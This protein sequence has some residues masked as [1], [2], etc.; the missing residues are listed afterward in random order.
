MLDRRRFALSCAALPATLIS[1]FAACGK[2]QKEQM[3]EITFDLGKNIA[4]TA[5]ASGVPQYSTQDVNGLL[6]YSVSGIPAEIPA[7]FTRPGFEIVWHPLFGFELWADKAIDPNLL[8]EQASLQLANSIRSHSAAQAFV[9]QT[10]AQFAK[11]KW[12][13]YVDP[14]WNTLL[15]GRS[16]LLDES[17][18]IGRTLDAIDPAYKIP[19]AD[20][21]AVMSGHPA[22]NWV[23]DNVH[24]ELSCAF[25]ILQDG[26]PP[27]Y[28]M[29]LEFQ[30]LDIK[31]RRAAEKERRELKEGDA[32]GWNST[33]KLAAAKNERAALLKRLE[34]N[35]IS[36]GDS[37]VAPP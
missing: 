4:D 13:R 2:V 8:V 17:G 11:G 30:V 29:T 31:L 16:S 3:Q 18:S 24:A 10:I 22:W 25:D 5:K 34:A 19:P 32:K 12:K 21:L 26:Q 37:V 9:E 28:R 14:V 36:R 33:A 6:I 27:T 1:Q 35:A 7:R 23:G 20:W 15:T